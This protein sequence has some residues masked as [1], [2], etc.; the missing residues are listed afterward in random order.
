MRAAKEKR[1]WR[2]SERGPWVRRPRSLQLNSPP[3]GAPDLCPLGGCQRHH[4]T[5]CC[6]CQGPAIPATAGGTAGL[7]LAPAPL[8]PLTRLYQ[9]DM[10]RGPH[11]RRPSAQGATES[12]LRPLEPPCFPQNSWGV[13]RGHHAPSASRP[14]GA[15]AS[16]LPLASAQSPNACLCTIPPL[17]IFTPTLQRRTFQ[18]QSNES[19]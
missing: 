16:L 11:P 10:G 2:C 5:Y 7:L 15:T 3:G 14:A 8:S 9:K 18:A 4:L 6:P 1:D 19:R 17:W 12:L 13:T